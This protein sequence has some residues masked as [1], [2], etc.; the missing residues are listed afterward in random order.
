[1][2]RGPLRPRN[3]A[4]AATAAVVAASI[5]AATEI[6]GDVLALVCDWYRRKSHWTMRRCAELPS[7]NSKKN[8]SAMSDLH[9]HRVL[10]TWG[11]TSYLWLEGAGPMAEGSDSVGEFLAIFWRFFCGR[12]PKADMPSQGIRA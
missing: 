12:G 8:R 2:V 11:P 5:A 3:R 7:R 1:M 9:S 10:R 4:A 6:C